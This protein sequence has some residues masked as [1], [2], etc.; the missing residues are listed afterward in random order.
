VDTPALNA[1]A[2]EITSS[3]TSWST[4]N[5]GTMPSRASGSAVP[6]ADYGGT[7]EGPILVFDDDTYCSSSGGGSWNRTKTVAGFVWGSV[8]DVV[9][10]GPASQRSIHVR[11]S[12]GVEREIGVGN[13][14]GPDYGLT[15]RSQVRLIK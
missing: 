14:P 4:S 6:A 12:T 15:G 8:Y 9:S 7:L 3:D 1:I 11:L 13:E 10:S 2:R 5:W